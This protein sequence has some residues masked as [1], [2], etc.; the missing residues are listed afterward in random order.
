MLSVCGVDCGGCSYHGKECAGCSE[1]QGNVF[2]VQY[3][4]ADCCPIYQCVREKQLASCGQCGD[5]PCK[6]WYELKDPQWSEAEHQESIKK[7][8]AALGKL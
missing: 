2:W 5:I 1:V 3:I 6:T 7:R 8:L 4:N